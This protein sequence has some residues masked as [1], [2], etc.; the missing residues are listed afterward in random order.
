[1]VLSL[2]LERVPQGRCEKHDQDIERVKCIDNMI[3]EKEGIDFLLKFLGEVI[4]GIAQ[5]P[6]E[7]G[8][9]NAR[10]KGQGDHSKLVAH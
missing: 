10:S 6:S 1:M 4:K 7:L 3:S 9:T 8:N 5:M 2:S